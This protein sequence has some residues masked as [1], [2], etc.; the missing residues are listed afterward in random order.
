MFK[1]VSALALGAGMVAATSASA[2]VSAVNFDAVDNSTA[3]NGFMTTDINIDFAGE[4]TGSQLLLNLDSGSF[5]R[6][7]VGNADGSSP[8]PAFFPTFPALEFDSYVV[9]SIGGGAVDLGGAGTADFPA[10]GGTA[11]N[12]A[13]NPAPGAGIVDQNGFQTARITLSSDAQGSFTYLASVNGQLDRQVGGV[14][15]GKLVVP[16]PTTAGLL[17]LAGLSL[18]A[19]RRK[20]A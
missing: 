15:D 20:T 11:L 18:I 16:E 13:W 6:D 8:N 10:N 5:Y 3:L 7:A 4:W 9:G 17:G 14:I 2:Q 12:Q 19:R 1:F